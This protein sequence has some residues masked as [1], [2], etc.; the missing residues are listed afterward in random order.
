MQAIKLLSAKKTYVYKENV[1]EL[2]G[3]LFLAK[4][5]SPW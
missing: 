2:R 5:I 1:I 4:K 3:I